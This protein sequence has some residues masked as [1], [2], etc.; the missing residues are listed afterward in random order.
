MAVDST[1]TIAINGTT[2]ATDKG[3]KI[4]KPGQE[5]DKNSFLRI[6]VAEL[7]NQDPQN[8][9]DSTA[10]VAQ[11][12]QFAGLEQMA[13]LNNNLN[14]SNATSLIGKIVA[15]SSADSLGNQYGGVVRGVYK[16]S[17]GVQLNV[18]IIENGK[19]VVKDFP[20]DTVTD[21]IDAPTVTPTK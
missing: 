9:K 7:S 2:R 6:L 12:A 20:Y 14:F 3:T 8:A 21:V 10:Y 16:N 4:Q 11:M 17:A 19:S 1:Q 18:Q 15:F 13:N 5:M